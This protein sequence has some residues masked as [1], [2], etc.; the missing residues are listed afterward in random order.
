MK[1]LLERILKEKLT[2]RDIEAIVAQ[3]KSGTGIA[4]KKKGKKQ[5]AELISLSEELQRKIGT[6]VKISGRPSKGKIEI[7]YYSLKELERIIEADEIDAEAE[8]NE[9]E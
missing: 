3:W 2:V 9:I 6:K 5:E 1:L 7:H 8:I 4:G